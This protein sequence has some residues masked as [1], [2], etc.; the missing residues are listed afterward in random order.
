[1]STSKCESQRGALG[2]FAFFWAGMLVKT[3]RVRGVRQVGAKLTSQK[4]ESPFDGEV[5]RIHT[6]V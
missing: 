3:G 4:L 2:S 1:M 6:S 5:E